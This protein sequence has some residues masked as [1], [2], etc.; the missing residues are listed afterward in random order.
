MQASEQAS[1]QDTPFGA[2]VMQRDANKQASKQDPPCQSYRDA[3][4]CKQANKAR[5]TGAAVVQRDASKQVH[6]TRLAGVA[7][8]QRDA[9]MHTR[10]ALSEL[11]R[12][13][14][15]Q[16]SKQDNRDAAGCKQAIKRE[17]SFRSCHDVA[18]C[19]QTSKQASKKDTPCQSYRDAAGCMTRLLP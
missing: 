13:S 12:C 15:M 5:L 11:P 3:T 8:M 7:V 16:A 1:K 6:K 18:G 17:T 14:G 2:A 9:S 19:K 10:H 4:G